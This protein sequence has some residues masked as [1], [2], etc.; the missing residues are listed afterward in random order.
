[1]DLFSLDPGLTVWTWFCFAVLCLILTKWVFPPFFRNLKVREDTIARSIDDAAE[2]EAR[3]K[4]IETERAEILRQT[5]G[6]AEALLKNAREE[7][8]T[9]KRLLREEAEREVAALI[10]EG[11]TRVSEER[12]AAIEALR[13]ELA[14][15]VL[16]CAGTILGSTLSGAKEREWSRNLVK[17][18]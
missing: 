4:G 14:E 15:F 2:I 10:A 6:E 17:N 13:G 9:L 16:T 18:L 12:Q 1:M 3:L 8:E 7:A 11:K 5:R